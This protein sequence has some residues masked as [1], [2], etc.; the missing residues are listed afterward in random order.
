[1]HLKGVTDSIKRAK[2]I[3]AEALEKLGDSAFQIE[4]ENSKSS[5]KATEESANYTVKKINCLP[6]THSACIKYGKPN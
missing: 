5:E 1:L 4:S 3:S 6:C 2:V